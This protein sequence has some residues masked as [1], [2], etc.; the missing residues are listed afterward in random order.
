MTWFGI[1]AY[2]KYLFDSSWRIVFVV[3]SSINVII[4]LLQLALVSGK[5][6]E[7]G[8]PDLLFAL[9]DDGVQEVRRSCMQ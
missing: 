6:R 8:I 7:W 3:C 1:I 2:E 9:G 5:S 4:G